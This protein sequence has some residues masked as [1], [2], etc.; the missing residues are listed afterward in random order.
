MNYVD[1]LE[2]KGIT[3]YS[4]AG[5]ADVLIHCP[6]HDD[7]KP[8][9][10][11]NIHT[12]QFYCFGCKE[13]GGFVRL[14]SEVSGIT[15]DEAKRTIMDGESVDSLFDDIKKHIENIDI[16]EREVPLYFGLDSF[17]KIFLSVI[18]TQGMKYLKGRNINEN[19]AIRFNLRWGGDSTATKWQERVIIPIYTE[20]GKLLS[21]AGRTII[22]NL[23]PK[24][25]KVS[26][27][28][29]LITLFGL[30]QLLESTGH[31]KLPY[32]I[33]NEGEFDSMYLQQNG[34]YAVAIMGTAKLTGEQTTL[35]K[36]HSSRVVL[37]YDGDNAGRR[38]Q[39]DAFEH[40]KKIMPCLTVSLP[41]GKDPNDL[42]SEEIKRF[43]KGV[44]E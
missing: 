2:K 19:T 13:S 42:S 40:L 28:S 35:L 18:G 33:V 43:Y 27:R 26:G 34:L 8:S 44:I 24:T 7:Q 22:K 11:V 17:E 38:A 14:L 6:F 16:D 32:I 15:L 41:E 12:G 37:S 20:K 10:E 25:R 39:K 5:A 21:W 4:G 29:P 31:K 30:Y 36:R 9:C 1:I 3:T 23:Q